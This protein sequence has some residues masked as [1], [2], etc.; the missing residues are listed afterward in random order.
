MNSQYN[1]VLIEISEKILQFISYGT[2]VPAICLD[3]IWM[4]WLTIVVYDYFDVYVLI[5]KFGIIVRL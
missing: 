4:V 5:T 3:A 2:F 1:C